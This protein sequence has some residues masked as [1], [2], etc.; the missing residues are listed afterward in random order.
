[1]P[2]TNELEIPCDIEA[3][4][5]TQ[6]EIQAVVNYSE[7]RD[8]AEPITNVATAEVYGET[9]ATTSEINHIIL[10]NE[11]S[12]G[13]ED[14]NLDDNDIAAGNRT[15]TGVAW[16]DANADGILN[17]NEEKLSGIT[18]R[19][20]NVETNNYV[21]TTD[22]DILEAT[23]NDNGV[24]V[25][26]G[27]GNGR[28]I[29]I[30]GYDD[31]RYTLTRYKVGGATGSENSDV[32]MNTL[33]IGDTE[34]EV[35]STDILEINNNNISDINIGLALLQDYDLQLDKYVSR[36]LLQNSKGTTVREYQDETMAKVELDA[37]QINGTTAIIEYQIRVTNVGDVTG[38]VRRIVDYLPSDLTFSSEMNKD[39]YQTGNGI[40]TAVLSNEP[41]APGESKTVTLTVVKNMNENNTG[42]IN[43]R[44]EIAEDYNDLGIAD[45]NST[46]GNQDTSEND[47]GSAD[48]ILSIRTGAV[49]YISI[50]VAV[51]IILTIIGIMIW[52]KKNHNKKI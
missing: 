30:F 26:D 9:I 22:G 51:I 14:N 38:Y 29:A 37:R 40:Y 6:I 48:V 25:L 13:N 49:T 11:G 36:I 4:G 2:D 3:G 28:Y 32:L 42:R 15:I 8:R 39:W 10:A 21:R 31:T 17:G 47:L 41:I 12:T 18:V 33:T 1:M 16:Y 52:K 27:I 24:Y 7:G 34:E 45:V 19:L 46:P 20:L 5:E 35:A 44:A 23:T 50:V 43:N